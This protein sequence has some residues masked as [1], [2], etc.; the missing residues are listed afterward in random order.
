VVLLL[1]VVFFVGE[2]IDRVASP[3]GSIEG[4]QQQAQLELT[5]K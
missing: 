3:D 2:K 5:H 1:V 4:Q